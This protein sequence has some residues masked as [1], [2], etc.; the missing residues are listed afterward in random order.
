MIVNCVLVYGDVLPSDEFPEL[1]LVLFVVVIN[2]LKREDK[3]V[4]F[5]KIFELF[6]GKMPKLTRCWN[7]NLEPALLHM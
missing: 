6:C 5:K 1:A 4:L 3:V 2:G 7:Q